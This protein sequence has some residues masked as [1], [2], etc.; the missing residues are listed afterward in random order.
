MEQRKIGLT[1]NQ[2]KL[3]AMLAMTLDHVGRQLFP[4]FGVFVILGRLAFPIFAYMIAEGCAHTRHRGRYLGMVFGLGVVCQAVYYF[5]YGSLYQ[6]ILITFTLSIATIFAIDR[7]RRK[8][9][10]FRGLVMTVTLAM[11]VFLAVVLPRRTGNEFWIDYGVFGVFLPVVIY[12]MPKKWA[13]LLGAAV[14]MAG[15]A[16]MLGGVQWYSML[17][18]PLL[19]LYNGQRGRRKLKYLFYIFYPVHLVIIYLISLII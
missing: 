10:F 8:M 16:W 4:Q 19:A 15:V 9:R 14:M 11:V 17:A 6:N 2:L 3:I 5:A 18:L 7:F 12:F 1:G 13:K